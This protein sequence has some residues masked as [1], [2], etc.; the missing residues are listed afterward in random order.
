LSRAAG[1][2]HGMQI[3]RATPEDAETIHRFV[4]ELAAYEREP[5]AVEASAATYRAQ[6]S[7]PVPPFECL[8][9]EENGEP[10]GFA[11]YFSTYSTWRGRRG[12]HLEDLWVTPGARRRGVGRALLS[13]LAAI[14]V[15]RGCARLEWSVLDWNESAM[16]FYRSLGASPLSEWNTWRADPGE[17]CRKISGTL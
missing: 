3:R 1:Y 8:V 17:L 9:A 12:I 13:R 7:E 15:E 6:L 2:N 16:A 10:L 14:A 5:D 11:L 4:C